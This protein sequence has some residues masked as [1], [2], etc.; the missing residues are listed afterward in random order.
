[1]TATAA[2]APADFLVD[3]AERS[4]GTEPGGLRRAWADYRAYRATLAELNTLT[5]RQLG[6]LGMTR[7]SLK[8]TVRRAVYGN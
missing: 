5:D 8:G 1:M 6:D 4:R 3:G 7:D 2:N